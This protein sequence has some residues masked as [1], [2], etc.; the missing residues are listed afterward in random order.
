MRLDVPGLTSIKYP[1]SVNAASLG[2]MQAHSTYMQRFLIL[3]CHLFV[4]KTK[5]MKL[6]TFLS[7]I[8]LFLGCTKT[9]NPQEIIPVPNGDFENWDA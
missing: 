7:I 4:P 9:N 3:R 6:V 5:D 1:I 2:V 8:T